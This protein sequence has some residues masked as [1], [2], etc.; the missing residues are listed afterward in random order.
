MKIGPMYLFQ[1]MN[2]GH[3]HPHPQ[4][5]SQ[6]RVYMRMNKPQQIKQDLTD[7]SVPMTVCICPHHHA[8]VA[9]RANAQRRDIQ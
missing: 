6:M 8:H 1:D 9:Q 7:C 5:K 3:R 2:R 4:N